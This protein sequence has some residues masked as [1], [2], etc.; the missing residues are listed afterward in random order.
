MTISDAAQLGVL[1]VTALAVFVT[2]RGVRDQ[3]WLQTFTDYT[4][5][6]LDA[7]E[8]FPASALRTE[9]P[10]LLEAMPPEEAV[11][12]IAAM[13]RFLNLCSEEFYLHLRRRIDGE[14]W[15][16]WRAGI[17]TAMGRPTFRSGWTVL[18]GEYSYFPEFQS[19]MSAML[20]GDDVE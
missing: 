12:F 2:L 15:R 6:Y 14:T 20:A 7:M 3:L 11:Q 10:V 16:V 19:F 17:A 5:R 8:R 1:L 18:A 13:R 9:S 4:K